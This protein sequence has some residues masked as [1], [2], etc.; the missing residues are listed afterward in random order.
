MIYYQGRSLFIHIPRTSGISLSKAVLNQANPEATGVNVI[1]GYRSSGLWRH[2]TANQ[3]R[4]ALP[5]WHDLTRFTIVRNPWRIV[6]STYRNLHRAALRMESGELWTTDSLKAWVD[7]AC[8]KPF[9]EFVV[10]HYGFL[11]RGFYDHWGLEWDTH[12]D[13]G[14]KAFRFEDLDRHWPEICDLMQLPENTVR[15]HENAAEPA[16]MDW[17]AKSV[18]FIRSRCEHDFVMFDYPRHP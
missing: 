9:G 8:E 10:W 12:N 14:V 1:L 16:E 7:E 17:T 6:E 13:L 15:P 5:D 3:L 11:S 4:K 2:S 18:A